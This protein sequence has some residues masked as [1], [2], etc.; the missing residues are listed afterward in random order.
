MRRFVLTFIML[1]MAMLALPLIIAKTINAFVG[2]FVGIGGGVAWYLG[3]WGAVNRYGSRAYWLYL[4]APVG[5]FWPVIL[6]YGLYR[7]G[8]GDPHW[9]MP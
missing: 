6:V 9:M 5:L 3:I 4:T 8:R 1:T 7:A 2:M